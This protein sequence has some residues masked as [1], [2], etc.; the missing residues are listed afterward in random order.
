[1][2]QRALF[3]TQL[4]ELVLREIADAQAL[5]RQSLA[6]EQRKLAGDRAQQRRFAR[7]VGSEQADALPRQDRPVDAVQDRLP[8]VPK[9]RVVELDELSGVNFRC[10]KRERKRAI[11]VRGGDQFHALE[12]FYPALRLLGL[13]RLGPKTVDVRAQVRDLP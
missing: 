2:P 10:R 12:R 8:G 7:A 13:A 5:R 1:M 6:I 11:D 4:L 3:Q 9:R